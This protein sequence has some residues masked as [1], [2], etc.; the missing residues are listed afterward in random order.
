MDA[1]PKST[2]LRVYRPSAGVLLENRRN[3]AVKRAFLVA[4]LFL[5]GI[6]VLTGVYFL[7]NLDSESAPLPSLEP[8]ASVSESI[9]AESDEQIELTPDVVDEEALSDW[10]PGMPIP[11][12]YWPFNDQLVDKRAFVENPDGSISWDESYAPPEPWIVE[13]GLL[14]LDG[15]VT[16]SILENDEWV[17]I[18][19]DDERGVPP[20]S[21]AS[22]EAGGSSDSV[23]NSGPHEGVAPSPV[24]NF[25]GAYPEE[26]RTDNPEQEQTVMED[27]FCPDE[28]S[29]NPELYEAC[30]GGFVAPDFV[31]TGINSCFAGTYSGDDF[32]GEFAGE[33]F[34]QLE[35]RIEIV[36]GNYR[37]H[38]MLGPGRGWDGF[39]RGYTL[40]SKSWLVGP[41]DHEV[42]RQM[43]LSWYAQASFYPM[44][45]THNGER[46]SGRKVVGTWVNT[47]ILTADLPANCWPPN[48]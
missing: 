35:V 34:I 27:V 17:D 9:A 21:R 33:S 43:P 45:D 39:N 1:G 8:E 26:N 32:G 14:I 46:L 11:D 48:L 7:N 18:P 12:G 42:L 29:E 2:K 19:C 16:C 25:P 22:S 30:W 31:L 38:S 13:D 5:L 44:S 37:D 41:N 6:G 28:P 4:L 23:A 10:K 3:E 36:G 15:T 20:E 24:D 40:S 47:P